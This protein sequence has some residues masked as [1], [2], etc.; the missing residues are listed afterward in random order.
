MLAIGNAQAGGAQDSPPD[1]LAQFLLGRLMITDQPPIAGEVEQARVKLSISL[2]VGCLIL[3]FA[4]AFQVLVQRI[5][6]GNLLDS[7]PAGKQASGDPGET[8]ADIVEVKSLFEADLAHE[9]AAVAHDLHQPG[10]FE[11]PGGSRRGPRLTFS[12]TA[13]AFSFKRSPAAISP[14]RIMRSI[15]SRTIVVNDP[16]RSGPEPLLRSPSHRLIVD[17]SSI[18]LNNMWR[19]VNKWH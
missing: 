9:D 5:E 16:V 19:I 18:S 11:R 10:L 15:F 1:E 13:I 7:H 6:H 17:N 2:V 3:G 4:G 14:L 8:R 12:W